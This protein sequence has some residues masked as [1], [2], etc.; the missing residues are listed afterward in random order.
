MKKVCVVNYGI[1][2]ISSVCKALKNINQDYTVVSEAN[3]ILNFENI[4]LPGVGSFDSGM[5]SMSKRGFDKYLKKAASKGQFILG[6]CL[7]MQLLF[8]RSQESTSDTKG[9]NVLKGNV[10]KIEIDKHN[11]IYVPHVGWNSIFESETNDLNLIDG[12]DSKDFYFVNSYHVVPEDKKIIKYYFRHG[13]EYAAIIR[14][15]NII[16][17][18]FHPEKSKNGLIILNNFCNLK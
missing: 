6:I 11:G 14:N 15:E 17:T 1:N 16:A 5:H 2:N 9:L 10:S 18:Q 3:K 13:K 4:I 7:G 8:S 12:N